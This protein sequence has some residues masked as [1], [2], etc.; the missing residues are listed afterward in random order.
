M[1]FGDD[2]GRG[3]LSVAS[4]VIDDEHGISPKGRK[5]IENNN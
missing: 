1:N 3:G 2:S 5:S 4:Y